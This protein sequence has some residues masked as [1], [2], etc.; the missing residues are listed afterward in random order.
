[1]EHT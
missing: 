1:M